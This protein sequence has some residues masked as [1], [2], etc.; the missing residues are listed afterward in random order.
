VRNFL[1]AEGAKLFE[2]G[3]THYYD[4]RN[5]FNKEYQ[6]L[7][8]LFLNRAGFNGMIRFNRK[9]QFNIPFTG[10]NAKLAPK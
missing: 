8:F 4:V 7:D 3:E 9:G 2:K 10:N 1:N 5:R 6:P